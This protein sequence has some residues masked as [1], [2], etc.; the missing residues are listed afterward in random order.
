[1]ALMEIDDI[2]DKAP[3]RK[4]FATAKKLATC[5]KRSNP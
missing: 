1:M 2:K 3:D 4:A 5:P